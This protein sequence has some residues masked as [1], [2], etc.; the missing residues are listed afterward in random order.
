MLKG[1]LN[2]VKSVTAKGRR[3]EYFDT[4]AKK[5][6]GQPILKRLPARSDPA[7]G[8]TYA[9]LLGGR[10]KRANSAAVMTLPQLIEAYER[11]AQFRGLAAATR[12]AY[13]IYLRLL[14][15]QL[16]AAPA[17]GIERR[18]LEHLREKIWDGRH[19]S[20]ARRAK[21]PPERLWPGAANGM[22]RTARALFKWARDR[23]YITGD[24][25]KGIELFDSQDYQPWPAGLLRAGLASEDPDIRLP[26]A[27]LYFTA[28]R[29]GDVCSMRWSDIRDGAIHVRQQKT[30]K[31]L[32]IRLHRELAAMLAATPRTS[33]TVIA[34]SKGRP[35][36]TDPVRERLQAFAAAHWTEGKV[37]PHGLRKNA[38]IALLEAGCSIAETAAVSGQSLRMVEHYAK[39][40][41]NRFLASAAILKMERS[42]R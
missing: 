8:D 38:V 35:L 15:A 10:T 34:D 6:S 40:R 30:G 29:I 14:S 41:G 1:K 22:I 19:L 7:F 37:V 27:L 2:F 23:E 33:L 11:S 32:E 18:D 31:E 4:G 24:P 12:E 42:K 5:A 28:Q 21:V 39:A 9:A 25:C 26:I 16:G 20:P 17:H 3:Y 13:G 36:R